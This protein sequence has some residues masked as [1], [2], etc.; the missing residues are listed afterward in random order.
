MLDKNE[1]QMMLGHYRII[2][3]VGEGAWGRSTAPKT[4]GSAARSR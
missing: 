1:P 4:R 3:K 2:E